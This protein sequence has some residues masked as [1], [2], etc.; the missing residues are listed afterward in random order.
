MF[1]DTISFEKRGFLF[2]EPL[3]FF[4]PSKKIETFHISASAIPPK[5]QEIMKNCNTW[6]ESCPTKISEL[7]Y[8]RLSY[9]CFQETIEIGELI[10]ARTVFFEIKEIFKR[11]FEIRFPIQ[12]ILPVEAFTGSDDRSM[13]ANNS[14]CFSFRD[15]VG[16]PGN[17]S[18]HSYGTALDINPLINPYIRIKD[19]YVSDFHEKRNL[20]KGINKEITE[21]VKKHPEKG[22][23]LPQKAEINS[24]LSK[25]KIDERIEKIF[26]EYG[27]EWGGRWPRSKTERLRTDPHHFQKKEPIVS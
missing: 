26:E 10:A 7:C 1:F 9:Y 16:F 6:D 19:E 13:A 5:M 23:I 20:S 21:Y 17:Y 14:Y 24:G 18:A 12:S 25:G 4:P 8:I 11:L 2:V 22:V 3:L 15:I 27:W